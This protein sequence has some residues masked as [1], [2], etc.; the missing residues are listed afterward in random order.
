[1]YHIHSCRYCWLLH[2]CAL[3]WLLM[4]RAAQGC[5]T[6]TPL[7]LS[8]NCVWSNQDWDI[9]YV[10]GFVSL[11]W[12]EAVKCV[13]M[14]W[15]WI[16]SQLCDYMLAVPESVHLYCTCICLFV[17]VWVWAW[18]CAC[19]RACGCVWLSLTATMGT[20][21][22][23]T[24]IMSERLA[25]PL[26][27]FSISSILPVRLG[28]TFLSV[29]LFL[30]WIISVVF[31]PSLCFSHFHFALN[32]FYLCSVLA[33]VLID[34]LKRQFCGLCICVVEDIMILVCF[35]YFCICLHS[36]VLMFA[37]FYLIVGN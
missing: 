6:S 14:K 16:D 1:M 32:F 5:C 8:H 24:L 23:L 21:F 4:S 29:F 36:H 22:I 27:H 20:R 30:V 17:S 2:C 28:Y 18:V 31:I 12:C 25:M 35:P 33:G 34:A 13:E 11:W 10:D 7:T 19:A 26:S 15:I 9:G 37:P 3:I